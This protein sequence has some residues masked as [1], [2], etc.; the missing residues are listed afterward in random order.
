M[1]VAAHMAHRDA[2]VL[3]IFVRD[4]DEFLAALGVEFGD[5]QADHLPFGRRGKAEIG[6]D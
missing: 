1:R 3:G 6:G 4:L 2:R 5:A